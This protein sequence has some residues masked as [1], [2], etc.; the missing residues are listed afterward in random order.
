MEEI[1]KQ[2]CEVFVIMPF[3]Q[4]PT[5]T[6]E[7]LTEFFQENLKKRLETESLRYRY[8]VKRSADAFNITETIIRDLHSADIVLCDLSGVPPNPNVM[9]ELGIR[10]AISDRPVVL[11][12]EQHVDNRLIFDVSGF[13]IF[14][15]RPQQYRKLEDYVVEKIRKFETGEERFQSPFCR[16]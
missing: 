8:V 11:F 6:A 3:S 13:H 16:Y 7:D 15:Y 1:N 14:E 4:A 2:T 9:Y 12:R 5:R 10:L